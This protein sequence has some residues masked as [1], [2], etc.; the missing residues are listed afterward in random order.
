MITGTTKENTVT[1][2][3]G[4]GAEASVTLDGVNIDVGGTGDYETYFPGEAAVR[5][6]GEG[7]VTMELDGENTV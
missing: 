6:T 7:D 5:I 2:M 4:K 1:I 3:A